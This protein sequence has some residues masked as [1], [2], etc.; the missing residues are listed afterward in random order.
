MFYTTSLDV[1]VN[2]QEHHGFNESYLN[3]NA[4]NTLLTDYSFDDQF[5]TI[6]SVGNIVGDI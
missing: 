3:L 4:E 6:S 2:K 1:T 5:W